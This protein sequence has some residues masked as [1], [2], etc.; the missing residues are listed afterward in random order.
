VGPE[1][2]ASSYFS[3]QFIEVFG[4]KLGQRH[5]TI[6]SYILRHPG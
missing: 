2:S 6:D 3:V 1:I 5:P 4:E